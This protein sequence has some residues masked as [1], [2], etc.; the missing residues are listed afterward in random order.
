MICYYP[1]AKNNYLIILEFICAYKV[2]SNF[3]VKNLIAF[4]HDTFK[5]LAS[6]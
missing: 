1:I 5:D 3:N 6:Y 2:I 4:I